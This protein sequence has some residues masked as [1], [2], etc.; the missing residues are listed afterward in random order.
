MYQTPALTCIL[1]PGLWTPIVVM[2]N[3]KLSPSQWDVLWKETA[4][5]LIS[6]VELIL[7]GLN[8]AWMLPL[9]KEVT[10]DLDICTQY[11]HSRKMKA[12]I[13]HHKF[14]PNGSKWPQTE[15]ENWD[16]FSFCLRRGNSWK[17]SIKT[18]PESD[19]WPVRF[20]THTVVPIL[21]SDYSLA[22]FCTDSAILRIAKAFK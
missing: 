9:W 18:L 6:G 17:G 11:E 5:I 22:I 13:R 16:R 2:M 8:L 20:R 4:G 15:E 12:E 10:S 21:I 19:R 7:M 3:S 14:S 1:Q